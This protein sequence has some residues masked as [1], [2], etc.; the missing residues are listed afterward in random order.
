MKDRK[1]PKDLIASMKTV[2]QKIGD[3]FGPRESGF[4][5]KATGLGLMGL[6]AALNP[7]LAPL[8]PLAAKFLGNKLGDL[9]ESR[10]AEELLDLLENKI[11][12]VTCAQVDVKCFGAACTQ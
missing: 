5:T 3:L 7:M 2:S 12:E 10:Q 11:S 1:N 9:L 8:A 4:G 6:L